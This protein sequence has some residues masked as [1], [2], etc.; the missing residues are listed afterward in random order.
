MGSNLLWCPH[1]STQILNIIEG[2][3]LRFDEDFVS[4]KVSKKDDLT[5]KVIFFVLFKIFII[6]H[7]H[8]AVKI[9]GY[10]AVS[11]IIKR[12][13][14]IEACNERIAGKCFASFL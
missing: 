12:S 13:V 9:K 3:C 1:Y 8:D 11:I 14:E 5:P 6:I 4:N 10:V 7:E 2:K